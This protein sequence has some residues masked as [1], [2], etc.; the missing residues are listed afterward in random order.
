MLAIAAALV[1]AGCGNDSNDA[2][3]A[4]P[5]GPS[6]RVESMIL[7]PTSFEDVIQLTGSVE[8]LDDAVLSAQTA[9]TVIAL[10]PLGSTVRSGQSVAQLEPALSRSAVEQA[11]ARV[12]S[13]QAQFD[14]AEDNLRRNEPLH[15]DSVI[16]AVE[17]ENVR[18]RYN[19][20]RAD[21]SQAQAALSQAQEQMRQTRV[22]APFTGTVEEHFAEIGEQL[23]P[24]RQV[25]R[26]INTNRVKVVAGVPERYSSDIASGTPVTVDF[27]AYA[28]ASVQSEISFVGRAI[29]PD[30]RTFPV[31]I[32]IPNPTGTYKPEMVAQVYVTRRQIDDALVAP[33]S[34]IVRDEDGT[35]VF[36]VEEEG[37][38]TVAA[39]S[40]VVLGPG[41]GGEV[42]VTNLQPGD[43]IV[44]LGQNNLTE[45]DR[46]QVMERHETGDEVE[47][48][49]SPEE[50]LPEPNTGGE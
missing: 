39:K 7:S 16:S 3:G 14:L 9:G 24:G 5:E 6:V 28:G 47:S 19:Q 18:A 48:A 29:D 11:E 38:E 2:Q 46:V 22:V 40:P 43:E 21:L 45:G 26:I 34:A 37:D 31:E 10:A 33:R 12:E 36:L 50:R 23:T 13:A 27:R 30:S 44:V 42:V 41:Y 32:L 4:A 17:W 49:A 25:A 1:L 15:R 35:S 20:A 8:A